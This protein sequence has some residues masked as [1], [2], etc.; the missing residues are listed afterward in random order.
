MAMPPSSVAS[1]GGEAA[2]ELADRG[3]GG[4][5]DDGLGHGPG[6]LTSGSGRNGNASRV[7][8]RPHAHV[9]DHLFP[10]DSGADTLVV[11]VFDGEAVAHD[12]E[13][14]ALQR[15]LDARRGP[16]RLPPPR[17][18]ARRRAA[19]GC[20]SASARATRSTP[21]ARA[22]RPRS[23]SGARRSSGAG[24]SAGS[25][26]TTS[27]TP[28]P[29]RSSRARCSPPTASTRY[30]RARDDDRA[31]EELIVS[32]HHDVAGRGRGGGRGRRGG[33]PR[34]RPAEHARQRPDAARPSPTRPARSTGVAV[35]VHG[36]DCLTDRG[37]GRLR[38]RRAGQRHTSPP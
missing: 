19:A 33:Q 22:S 21:S 30:K 25:C 32:A 16:H 28:W 1:S 20:S 26:P 5:E 34:A 17:G 8:R 24:G 9:S 37:H 18:R 3:A 36:R 38:R 11:G 13:D 4:T 7:C 35:E 31:V 23:P 29:A 6:V 10:A 2:A 14:G 12:V 15:L 27:T